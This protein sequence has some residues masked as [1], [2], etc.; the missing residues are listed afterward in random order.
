[1]F[2]SLPKGELIVE[3]IAQTL[4]A[5]KQYLNV[6]KGYE[7]IIPRNQLSIYII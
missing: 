7:L 3:K 2:I 4:N 1:M 5:L 6:D